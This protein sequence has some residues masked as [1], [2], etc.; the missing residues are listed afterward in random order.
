MLTIDL[1]KCVVS[2]SLICYEI[3]TWTTT[4]KYVAFLKRVYAQSAN[5]LRRDSHHDHIN[6]MMYTLVLYTYFFCGFSGSHSD[7]SDGSGRSGG[8]IPYRAFVM[9]FI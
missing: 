4:N 1:S 7:Y 2:K 8:Q 6:L 9:M 3:M 5:F